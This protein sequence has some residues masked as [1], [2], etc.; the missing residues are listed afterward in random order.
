VVGGGGGVCG[1]G[2]GGGGR[3]A[4]GGIRGYGGLDDYAHDVWWGG[5]RAST[6]KES[7]SPRKAGKSNMGIGV[8]KKRSKS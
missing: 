8:E 5:F 2:R 3:G 4:T 7:T 1:R 6:I